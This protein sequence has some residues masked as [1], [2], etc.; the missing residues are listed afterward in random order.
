[1]GDRS[2]NKP[3]Q[4]IDLKAKIRQEIDSVPA[5]SDQHGF[6]ISLLGLSI[7]FMLSSVFL[8]YFSNENITAK[9]NE[10]I[11]Q[12]QTDFQ[13]SFESARLSLKRGLLPRFMIHVQNVELSTQDP[14]YYF[15][16]LKS[17]FVE[18]PISIFQLLR[19]QNP[20]Q[21]LRLTTAE[22]R[23][24]P[25]RGGCFQSLDSNGRDVFRQVIPQHGSRETAA[26]PA[27]QAM[28]EGPAE[29]PVESVEIDQLRIFV[30]NDQNSLLEIEDLQFS[31]MSLK[32]R[33]IRLTSK[34]HLF[35]E[36]DAQDFFT[37]GIL[38]ADFKE[39]PEKQLE[40]NIKG[41]VREGSYQIKSQV[42]LEQRSYEIS[43]DFQHVPLAP[44]LSLF[45]RLKL[46]K[47]DF[48]AKKV[49]TSFSASSHGLLNDLKTAQLSIRPVEVEGE[50]GS[51]LSSEVLI[52]NLVNP[53]IS[54]FFVSILKLNL[55]E[56][57]KQ[58]PDRNQH[59]YFS[60]LGEFQGQLKFHSR[61][62]M[63]LS[64][65][66]KNLD[67][68][69][70][71]EG[72][73]E[74]Q[75]VHNIILNANFSNGQWK[76]HVPRAD[77][78]AGIFSGDLNYERNSAGD[79]NLIA[80]VQEIQFSPRVQKIMTRGGEIGMTSFKY[81]ALWNG[82]TTFSEKGIFRLVEL[83]AYGLEIKSIN[84]A[85][86]NRKNGHALQVSARSLI[87]DQNSAI[88]PRLQPLLLESSGRNPL[89]DISGQ[90][91]I[92]SFD[93]LTWTNVT[94][95]NLMGQYLIQ[96]SWD[97]S[98]SLSGSILLKSGRRSLTWNIAGERSNPLFIPSE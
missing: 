92:R 95:K 67:L 26:E 89:K 70:S 68:I 63:E 61:N 64:G 34:V 9:L 24:Y 5:V 35:K 57:L 66:H 22:L 79:Q 13:L 84:G 21:N 37:H 43:S 20:V 56:V 46:F 19:G 38:S 80:D 3:Q 32:D 69:F 11:K 59:P 83:N 8:N 94:A 50:V 40:F 49:W 72:K 76:A 31:L 4:K 7:A 93:N 71:N 2:K 10:A 44:I 53:E 17:E 86:Q 12:V 51:L 97:E 82:Q 1:M 58:I 23:L 6:A 14:C 42:N 16:E 87:I 73:R 65:I 54:P 91:E 29:Y 77:F 75:S 48:P 85:V 36:N 81:E 47:S 88:A 78:V 45:Q 15:S 62:Q 28:L 33:H 60:R 39:L 41:H 30:D 52:T 18:L 27:T 96:G 74:I 98:Q 55:D 25:G 90:F